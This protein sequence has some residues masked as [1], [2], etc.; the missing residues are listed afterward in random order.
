MPRCRE[1]KWK[2][3]E[4]EE[5][6]AEVAALPTDDCQDTLASTQ[7]NPTQRAKSKESNHKKEHV[8]RV[9]MKS[10]LWVSCARL[11]SDSGPVG[12]RLS[13]TSSPGLRGRVLDRGPAQHARGPLTHW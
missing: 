1:W 8:M 2:Q 4:A 6:G 10:V 9:L 11:L 7:K 13:L 5:G 12:G 3:M